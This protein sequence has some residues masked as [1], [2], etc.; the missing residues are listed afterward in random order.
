MPLAVRGEGMFIID[1]QGRKYLDAS[2]GAAVS[3]LGHAHPRVVEAIRDQVGRLEFAH[4]S[5][6]TSEPAVA[7]AARLIAA[8]S[9]NFQGGSVVFA[10]GGSEA[11]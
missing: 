8:A 5:F 2:G 9:P 1:A 11:I 10:S 4:T 7:L 6:F 3:C